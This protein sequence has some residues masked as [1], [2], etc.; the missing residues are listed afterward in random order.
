M[1]YDEWIEANVTETK[2]KCAEV[3]E[4]MVA[5]F[6]ELTRIRGHYYCPAWGE[7][8]HWW[9]VDQDGNIVDP[10]KAQFPSEGTG[11]YEPWDESQEE[12]TGKCPN[13]GGFIYGG[14]QVCSDACGS[15][16]TAYL[17]GDL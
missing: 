17:M 14:G 7:R 13:C 16:Y 5:A 6:P 9:C 11:H 2:G 4:Q 8:T 10:T 15:A 1:T 12:P 3:T